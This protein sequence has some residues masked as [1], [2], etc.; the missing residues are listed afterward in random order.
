MTLRNTQPHAVQE[1]A[2][3]QGLADSNIAVIGHN[4]EEGILCTE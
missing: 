3:V 2:V 1:G 4:G